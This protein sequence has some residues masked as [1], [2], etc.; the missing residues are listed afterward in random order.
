MIKKIILSIFVLGAVVAFYS[1]TASAHSALVSLQVESL[2]I[3]GGFDDDKDSNKKANGSDGGSGEIDS[4]HVMGSMEN[5]VT[6]GKLGEDFF[7]DSKRGI[8]STY[9]QMFETAGYLADSISSSDG[10]LLDG[11]PSVLNSFTNTETVYIGRGKAD[12]VVAGDKY[13]VVHLSKDPVVHPVTREDMGHKVLVDGIIEVY[14]TKDNHSKAKVIKSYD[15]MER[16][17]Y[18][19]PYSEP[20]QAKLD[21]DRPVVE[22]GIEGVLLAAREPKQG[23]ATGDVVYMDIG[24]ASGVEEG[25]VFDII[26]DNPVFKRSGDLVSGF[27]K[28]VGQAKVISIREGTSTAY[29]TGSTLDSHA[30]YPVVYSKVR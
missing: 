23:F 9:L 8:T 13:Y 11:D 3:A 28:V 30:G 10:L 20:D 6:S 2:F 15:S 17:D 4:T 16:G 27:P 26:D 21:P 25:D 1:T 29:I 5:D 12:G 19:V 14:K 18:I 22:K 7:H 24:G